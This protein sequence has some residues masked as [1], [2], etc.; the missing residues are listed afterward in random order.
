MKLPFFK[1][2]LLILGL[3]LGS[4]VSAF[5]HSV[6]LEDT[7]DGQLVLRFGEFGDEFEKS[8]GHLDEMGYPVT[9]TPGAD[10]KPALFKVE[11]KSDHYLLLSAAPTQAALAETDYLVLASK[12]KPGRKPLF[13]ARWHVGSAAAVPA[14]NFDIVP[15]GEPGT[16]RVYFRGKPLPDV[17]ITVHVPK[18]ENQEL[19]ADK[20]GVA[21]FATPMPGLYLLTCAHQREP[22][23]G[24]SG[25][26]SYEMVSHNC[27]LAWRQP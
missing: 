17:K 12:D 7:P 8:P 13:Y 15:T 14:L 21:H 22:T 26:L 5:A 23:P 3:A 4:A 24:F 11:K 19:V 18:G 6:W 20:E 10:G 16:V 9:W 25:G 1:H 2:S 27:S